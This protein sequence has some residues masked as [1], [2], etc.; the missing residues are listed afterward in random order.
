MPSTDV[1]P[2]GSKRIA[3]ASVQHSTGEFH[4]EAIH[5][6]FEHGSLCSW[7]FYLAQ[8]SRCLT[9]D[10][11]AVSGKVKV[12]VVPDGNHP[13]DILSCF[14]EEHILDH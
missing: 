6:L 14:A 1:A 12:W 8:L 5:C 13:D 11:E 9:L 4:V 2:I 3:F 10:L 7:G